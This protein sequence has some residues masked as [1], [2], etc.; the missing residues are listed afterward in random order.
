MSSRNHSRRSHGGNSSSSR[1]S[2][3]RATQSVA[4]LIESLNTH[5]IN[6]LTELRRIERVAAGSSDEDQLAFQGPMT[7]AWNY[8]V[9]SH[10]LLNELRGLTRNYPFSSA[11]LDDAKWRVS[12]DPQS[13]RSWNYAWLVLIKMKD[14]QMIESYSTREAAAPDMWGGRVPDTDEAQQLAACFSWE[15]NEALSQLLRHWEAPPTTTGY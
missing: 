6:T 12:N 10:N 3:H 1:G 4:Q 2:S 9:T 5:R 13:N 7:N 15:W 14:D 11:A 8:Y